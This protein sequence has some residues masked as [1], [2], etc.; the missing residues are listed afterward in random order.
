MPSYLLKLPPSQASLEQL[1]SISLKLPPISPH[2]LILTGSQ[3]SSSS[4]K[5]IFD[6]ATL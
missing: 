1:V 2:A 6:V 4:A 3:Q 5:T